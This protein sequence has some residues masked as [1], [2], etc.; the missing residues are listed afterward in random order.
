[1]TL[2][3]TGF[4][5]MMTA[6]VTASRPAVEFVEPREDGPERVPP[7]Q[8]MIQPE[9][10]DFGST[11]CDLRMDKVDHLDLEDL[12]RLVRDPKAGPV[13]DVGLFE[14]AAARPRSRAFGEDAY[15]TLALKAAVTRRCDAR[16]HLVPPSSPPRF[17]EGRRDT[18]FAGAAVVPASTVSR[19]LLTERDARATEPNT[20]NAASTN[21]KTTSPPPGTACVASS[22]TTTGPSHDRPTRVGGHRRASRV[23][24]KYREEEGLG[25]ADQGS[26]MASGGGRMRSLA[27]SESGMG[28]VWAG[29]G[30]RW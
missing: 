18:S 2:P 28:W 23:C 27:N 8:V 17:G 6:R 13:R 22:E 15:A 19:L 21:S 5:V 24:S 25:P 11:S 4:D 30:R 29:S 1:M 10:V 7:A 16:R 12:L 3:P 14:S 9:L 26:R 20:P